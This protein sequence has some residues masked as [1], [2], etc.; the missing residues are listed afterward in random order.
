MTDEE[1]RIGL[2]TRQLELAILE[3]DRYRACCEWY[4]DPEQW[5]TLTDDRGRETLVFRWGDDG[6]ERARRALGRA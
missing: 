3:R 4:A 2:L 6:G 5:E 1:M